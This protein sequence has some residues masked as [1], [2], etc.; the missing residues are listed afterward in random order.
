MIYLNS[1][2]YTGVNKMYLFDFTPGQ[3]G[4]FFITL[5]SKCS[6]EFVNS[7]EDSAQMKNRMAEF[8]NTKLMPGNN[9][10]G[11]LIYHD[12]ISAY[13]QQIL[14]DLRN[15]PAKPI[16][17]CKSKISFC[18]HP[19]GSNLNTPISDV[20]KYCFPELPLQRVAL[21]MDSDI[22]RK[23]AEFYYDYDADTVH[24]TQEP[25]SRF[26]LW[27]DPVNTI[28]LDPI[29]L[30]ITDPEKLKQHVLQIS[31]DINWQWYNYVVDSYLKIKIKPF[32]EWYEQEK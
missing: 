29:D 4:D 12:S 32:L 25:G 1:F 10:G 30:L 9:I 23:F 7:W 6:S 22:S 28:K 8:Y 15:K 3:G 5:A 31:S 20:L 21:S 2:G 17:A 27:E 14:D 19:T 26:I 11:K 16:D 24:R 18:T 13:R